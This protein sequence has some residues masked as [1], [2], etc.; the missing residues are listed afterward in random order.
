MYPKPHTALVRTAT[1]ERI[2]PPGATTPRPDLARLLL[3]DARLHDAGR[4]QPSMK[5]HRGLRR[6]RGW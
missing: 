2:T 3:T 1:T 6:R 4:R 5:D